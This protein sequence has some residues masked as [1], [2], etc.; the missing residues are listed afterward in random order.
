MN[1]EVIHMPFPK[2]VKIAA[3]VSQAIVVL[4]AVLSLIASIFQDNLLIYYYNMESYI[5][6]N[7]DKITSW[8]VIVRCIA[9]LIVSG[10]N[11][12]ICSRKTVHAPIVMTSVTAGAMP[13][14]VR[15]V[16]S[17]QLIVTAHLEGANALARLSVVQ[18]IGSTLAYF[19]S[20]ALVITVAA[21][22][23]YSYA[24]ANC[25]ET[26]EFSESG[27]KYGIANN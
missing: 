9:A 11:I 18:Q 10:A 14:I 16:T 7:T 15:I 8:A 13:L 26:D 2:S 12:L 1:K 24:R 21:G 4:W 27:E 20:T 22:A 5:M 3:I 19:L 25:P 17:R 23:V 6:E